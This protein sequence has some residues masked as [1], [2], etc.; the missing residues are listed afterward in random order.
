MVVVVAYVHI[1]KQIASTKQKEVGL[2]ALTCADGQDRHFI[3]SH[4]YMDTSL[5]QRILQVVIVHKRLISAFLTGVKTW[6]MLDPGP[7]RRG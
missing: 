7:E 2:H 4:R 6:T 3:N 5:H 1:M